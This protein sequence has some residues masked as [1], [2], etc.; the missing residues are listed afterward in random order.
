MSINV[1][2]DPKQTQLHRQESAFTIQSTHVMS[3]QESNSTPKV[4]L[5]PIALAK[6]KIKERK[7]KSAASTPVK[8][9]S[10]NIT[11]STSTELELDNYFRSA[12]PTQSNPANFSQFN[13]PAKPPI[14]N[15]KSQLNFPIVPTDHP[16]IL[17]EVPSKV[18][19]L[20][21]P[22]SGQK[23]MIPI[24][25][26]DQ[27]HRPSSTIS[28][29][30]KE[31]TTKPPQPPPPYREAIYFPATPPPLLTTTTSS[32][33][34]QSTARTTTDSPELLTERSNTSR[35][36]V[37]FDDIY[38]LAV[39][40]D[41][42]VISNESM[43]TCK[44]LNIHELKSLP[45]TEPT[46]FTKTQNL[47]ESKR[48]SSRP[49]T[50]SIESICSLGN[51][52][53]RKPTL[54]ISVNFHG[55]D[56]ENEIKNKSKAVTTIIRSISG[57][58]KAKIVVPKPLHTPKAL[59]VNYH[60][61]T[62]EELLARVTTVDPKIEEN[63]IRYIFNFEEN[64][65]SAILACYTN[66]LKNEVKRLQRL[67]IPIQTIW[68]RYR[69]W[70]YVCNL[71]VT[72]NLAQLN[73]S[74]MYRRFKA[75][76]LYLITRNRIIILQKLIR[77]YLIRRFVQNFRKKCVKSQIF[78]SKLF[79]CYYQYKLY[80]KTRRQIIK[81]QSIV[82]CYIMKKMYKK[83]R[84]QVIL[85]QSI[86]RSHQTSNGFA[87]YK[88]VIIKIQT[89]L[90]KIKAMK[91]FHKAIYSVIQITSTFRGYLARKLRK[92]TKKSSLLLK[93]TRILYFI[94]L[95][96]K[97]Y[98]LKLSNLIK[99][100]PLI[101]LTNEL[102]NIKTDKRPEINNILQIRNY[103]NN[104]QTFTQTAS[105]S[106]IPN[107]RS[108]LLLHPNY[109]NILENDKIGNTSF[110]YAASVYN[111]DNFNY[112]SNILDTIP[113]NQSNLMYN[114]S[115]ID[116]L[117]VLH[118]NIIPSNIND[119][120]CMNW[121]M[122]ISSKKVSQKRLFVLT[123]THLCYYT[124]ESELSKQARLEISLENA[125]INRNSSI[126]LEIIASN[127]V[128]SNQLLQPK[129]TGTIFRTITRKS[130]SILFDNEKQ[131]QNWLY[132]MNA[133]IL[134]GTGAKQC[135]NDFSIQRELRPISY[136]NRKLLSVMISKVNKFGE[137]PLHLAIKSYHSTLSIELTKQLMITCAWLVNNS[138]ESIEMKD[139]FGKTPLDYAKL[140][141]FTD[142]IIYTNALLKSIQQQKE[143]DNQSLILLN[144]YCYISIRFYKLEKFAKFNIQEKYGSF[145]EK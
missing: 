135:K 33:S 124:N 89:F 129:K 106:I 34:A 14:S 53:T 20:S 76:T 123:K 120:L 127:E 74:M 117:T 40:H 111:L 12:E 113:I 102:Q 65:P 87:K 31:G 25:F 72:Y 97:K 57:K 58:G 142:F 85:I 119:C 122:K 90:R 112:L 118:N 128:T 94:R 93:H 45:S 67:V 134:I 26:P 80:K 24:A 61:E 64:I 46:V 56:I 108:L 10:R 11:K 52:N 41:E 73:I 110:H 3:R 68:R 104:Y 30:E 43:P 39:N 35:S 98:I 18:P 139:K 55:N 17:P 48:I 22:L 54:S 141:N 82:R 50:A 75:R 132:P 66:V 79:R 100:G 5:D 114:K 105:Q 62:V 101:E 91:D 51:N 99:N 4:V 140:N 96:Y 19:I 115:G 27:C 28:R 144:N 42:V 95:N 15:T 133:I 29:P 92:L 78:M 23:E 47:V 6:Q 9:T 69:E 7:A 84:K 13:S 116:E 44:S 137:N 136:I 131:L 2:D 138:I 70:K 86:I 103:W 77:G 60:I 16:I 71:R 32:H 83:T 88:K 145:R 121:L 81:M 130:V 36:S 49:S 143:K 8:A 37:K 1:T 21:F 38:N 125:I 109:Q 59:R 63:T 126:E 107:A